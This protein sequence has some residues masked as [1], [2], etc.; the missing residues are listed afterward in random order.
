MW[1]LVQGTVPEGLCV[2]HKCDNPSCINPNH[3]FIGTYKENSADMVRKGRSSHLITKGN[4]RLTETDVM[5]I[6]RMRAD[7]ATYAELS[8]LF[9]VAESTIQK[10]VLKS[11]WADIG[12]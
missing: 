4:A 2:C 7:R 10:V 8:A 11:T 5:E 9:N 3:L 12:A 1:E 6:R